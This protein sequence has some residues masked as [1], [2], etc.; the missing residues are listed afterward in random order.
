[1]KFDCPSSNFIDS[2]GY[3]EHAQGNHSQQVTE[4]R[5]RGSKNKKNQSPSHRKYDKFLFQSAAIPG[6]SEPSQGNQSDDYRRTDH[7]V[8]EQVTVDRLRVSFGHSEERRQFIRERTFIR[9]V[10]SKSKRIQQRSGGLQ[11]LP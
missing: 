6:S 1:M 11:V 5:V 4:L 9:R 8:I 10:G 7:P 2:A 3:P